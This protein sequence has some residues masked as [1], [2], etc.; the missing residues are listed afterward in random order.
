MPLLVTLAGFQVSEFIR[1]E[2]ITAIGLRLSGGPAQDASGPGR[3]LGPGP[4]AGEPVG[5]GPGQVG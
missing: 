1:T 4:A 3:G 2:L 5:P